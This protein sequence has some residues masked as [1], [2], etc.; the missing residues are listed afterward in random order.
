MSLA[1]CPP[2]RRASLLLFGNRHRLELIAAL[3]GA[4]DDGVN[5][6]ELAVRQGVKASV[7]YA[8]VNGLLRAGL[9]EKLPQR[10]PDRRRWYRR[11]GDAVWEPMRM[12]AEGLATIEVKAS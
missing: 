5:L 6:S 7:Y 2:G 1:E 11:T 10:L 8:P 3:A 12:L 9:V 4:D